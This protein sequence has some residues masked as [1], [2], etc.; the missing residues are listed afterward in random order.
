MRLFEIVG[1]ATLRTIVVQI[2]IYA[3]VLH[4]LSACIDVRWKGMTFGSPG[5]FFL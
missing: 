5:K 2:N 1:S 3:I 4:M